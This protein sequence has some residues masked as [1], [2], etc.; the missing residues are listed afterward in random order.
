MVC[1]RHFEFFA[2]VYYMILAGY[3]TRTGVSWLHLV[4]DE[5]VGKRAPI[6][7]W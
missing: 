5:F 3:S 4:G 6:P 7:L 1:F 2:A